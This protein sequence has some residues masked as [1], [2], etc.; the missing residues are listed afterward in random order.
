MAQS[1]LRS[2]AIIFFLCFV[3]CVVLIGIELWKRERGRSGY[4]SKG[5]SSD[6]DQKADVIEVVEIRIQ[7]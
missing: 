5:L 7:K 6:N 4:D 2:N 3:V 1:M